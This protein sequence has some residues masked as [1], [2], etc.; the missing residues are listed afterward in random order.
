MLNTEEKVRNQ[1]LM[2]KKK[3]TE[4]HISFLTSSYPKTTVFNRPATI[5]NVYAHL[6]E[7]IY[8]DDNLQ[9]TKAYTYADI[10]CGRLEIAELN[11]DS[12]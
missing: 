2:L 9:K 10:I 8:S 6:F 1:I 4:I 12:L 3:K 5:G 7:M 11:T